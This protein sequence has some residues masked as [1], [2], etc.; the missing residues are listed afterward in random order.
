MIEEFTSINEES[1]TF[2][3]N[4]FSELERKV[5]VKRE[6]LIQEIHGISD[7][8]MGEIKVQKNEI[9]TKQEGRKKKQAY[10][11]EQL[12]KY[13][14][15]LDKYNKELKEYSVD[16]NKWKTVQTETEEKREE[17][18]IKIEGLKQEL[19]CN[20]A[21]TFE[22]GKAKINS[23]EMFGEI[24]VKDTNVPIEKVYW[25]IS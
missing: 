3:Y 18:K 21:I 14:I 22:E 1:E 23:K 12:A 17:L 25:F 15:E 20:R 5:D 6:I 9:Q 16:L 2:I 24:I 10:D 8:L 7:K 4:Y 19:M 11:R 13:K